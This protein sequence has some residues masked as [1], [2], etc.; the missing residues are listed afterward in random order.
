MVVVVSTRFST[1]FIE[2]V[3]SEECG[4]FK[5]SSDLSLWIVQSKDKML[6]IHF[7]DVIF[8]AVQQAC[9]F[10]FTSEYLNDQK[11]L[12]QNVFYK[13]L[14][15]CLFM[16]DLCGVNLCMDLMERIFYYMI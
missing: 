8:N 11:P 13:I 9:K 1:I 10:F 3:S 16:D 14:L 5:N 15:Y 6:Q 2:T 4:Y 12:E 7:Q